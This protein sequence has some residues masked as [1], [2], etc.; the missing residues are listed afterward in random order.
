MKFSTRSVSRSG[1]P[2]TSILSTSASA[3]SPVRI[4]V[5]ETRTSM[6]PGTKG[7]SI[8][9]EADAV[10]SPKQIKIS[11]IGA[12]FSS[13]QRLAREVTSLSVKLADAGWPASSAASRTS[14]LSWNRVA[15]WADVVMGRFSSSQV[16]GLPAIATKK[17]ATA[18]MGVA[19]TRNPNRVAMS[20]NGFSM[21]RLRSAGPYSSSSSSCSSC[22]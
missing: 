17:K 1:K 6:S 11:S 16:P 10:P 21:E 9:A 2:P 8:W 3:T 7:M 13:N 22:D 5:P 19:S 14:H 4:N 12:S 15:S 18:A 20:R